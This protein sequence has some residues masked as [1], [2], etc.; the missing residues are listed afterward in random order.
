MDF[1]LLNLDTIFFEIPIWM[2]VTI[3]A[4]VM[5]FYGV[6][7]VVLSFIANRIDKQEKKKRGQEVVAQI[8]RRT[9]P[10]TILAIAV[11]VATAVVPAIPLLTKT[12]IW[13]VVL[14]VFFAQ[15]GIWGSA[16]VDDWIERLLAIL[17]IRDEAARTAMG[18]LRF[19]GLAVLWS[20][21]A[22]L[23]LANLGVNIA[24]LIAGLGIGGLAVAFALQK[25]LGDVFCSVAIVLDRPFEN[26]D[27]IIIGTEMGTIERIGIKTTRIRS[28][29]G[30]Q[31]IVSNADL[32]GS[33]I[34][35]YKRMM[36]RRVVFSFGV[37]YQ[38]A[39]DQLEQIGTMVREIVEQIEDARFD[40]AH[41]K[42]FGASS[43]DF[44]VVY[45]VTGNDYT[46]YMDIQ[47]RINL[48]L[49][50]RFEE[51]NIDFAYPT[52][53]LYVA[54]EPPMRIQMVEG[55]SP[56]DEAK[57]PDSKETA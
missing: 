37:I 36:E 4:F 53:T 24:P 8:I 16:F 50:R 2:W 56:N 49:V 3:L 14:V 46:K 28:L 7:R 30:E 5:L 15:A 44:E 6:A 40:R 55:I 29:G 57:T 22:V 21:I 42:Q 23:V 41:F 25:I 39:A 19:M 27:F 48:A 17:R 33:R 47:Q 11:L 12:I 52:Q 18:V 13:R 20:I 1:I 10:L 26:G 31:I 45:Y 38:T 34:R 35:N 54:N 9:N 51:H 43:L 32:L